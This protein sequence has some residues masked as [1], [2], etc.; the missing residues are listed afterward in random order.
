MTMRI[1]FLKSLD[2]GQNIGL[3]A[4]SF[5]RPL[6]SVRVQ[7]CGYVCHIFYPE[8]VPANVVSND[9]TI[10]SALRAIIFETNSIF[11]LS[12]QDSSFHIR[13]CE[14]VFLPRDVSA[15]RGNATVRRPSVCPSVCL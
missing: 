9:V 3:R 11:Q 12:S 10:T 14:T 1:T 8:V 15:E 6:L 7:F 13:N 4:L 2:T 5:K